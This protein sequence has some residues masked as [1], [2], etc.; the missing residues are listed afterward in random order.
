M[1]RISGRRGT[2]GA[3]V[4]APSWH[5]VIGAVIITVVI[6]TIVQSVQTNCDHDHCAIC[7]NEWR[8][9]LDAASPRPRYCNRHA[10]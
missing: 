4:A 5:R 2:T 6:M 1:G 3:S 10:P 7:A 8:Y 9:P